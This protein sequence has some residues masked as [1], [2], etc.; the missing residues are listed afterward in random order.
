MGGPG[1]GNTYHWWRPAKKTVVEHCRHLDANRWT[2]EGILR[3]GVR[4]SGGWRWTYG[5]TG[6][7]TAAIG[8]EVDTTAPDD[9][10]LWLTYTLTGT[11]ERVRYLVQ[12][13]RTRVHRGGSRWWFT[14]PL[15]VRDRP[16]GRRV[17]KLYLPPGGRY[18]GCRRC[19]DLTY[20]SCQEGHKYNS[21][22]RRLAVDT[23]LDFGLVKHAM[24]Q[25]GKE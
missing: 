8:Y 17:A 21:L 25:L 20:T 5:S 18:F 15:I 4:L 10:R 19:H 3:A 12:L 24:N 11:G 23:G 2:R 22:F 9:S 1:S 14:C 13:Q 16:C 7:E 6:E